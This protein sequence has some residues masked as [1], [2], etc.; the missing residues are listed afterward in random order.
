VLH[1]HNL[2]S[3]IGKHI[4]EFGAAI[5]DAG[6][7]LFDH[8][9]HLVALG[10]AICDKSLRLALKVWAILRRRDTRIDGHVMIRR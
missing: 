6:A 9:L 7:D 5:V 10:G 2:D 1:H 8:L 3:R 4:Q